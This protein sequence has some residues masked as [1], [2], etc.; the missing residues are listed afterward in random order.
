MVHKQPAGPHW[1]KSKEPEQALMF[2]LIRP[3]ISLARASPSRTNYLPK[4]S[5]P[6]PSHG[7]LGF[8]HVNLGKGNTFNPF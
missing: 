1:V 7:G 8:Q 4:A 2:L 3:L 5:P 6:T